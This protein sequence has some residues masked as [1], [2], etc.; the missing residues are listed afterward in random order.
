MGYNDK[1]YMKKYHEKNRELHNKKS[2]QYY[3]KNRESIRQQRKEY[4]QT[5]HGSK[6]Y[7]IRS[8]KRKGLKLYGYTYEE[9]Y[10]YYQSTNNCEVC[11]KPISGYG[12]CMDHCHVTGIFRW[13]LCKSC[14]TNDHWMKFYLGT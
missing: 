6:S 8:W 13:V 12:K 9:V 3:Q 2:R 10:E 14:N 7:M 4:R 1:D 11:N 5:P